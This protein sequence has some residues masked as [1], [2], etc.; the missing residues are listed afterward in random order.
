LLI[1]AFLYIFQA[2][3]TS[4]N[5]LVP[6]SPTEHV[7]YL[8]AMFFTPQD[9]AHSGSLSPRSVLGARHHRCLQPP[10]AHEEELTDE[11]DEAQDSPST[12][13]IPPSARNVSVCDSATR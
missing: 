5:M 8:T 2:P 10:P 4:R 6:V 7:F 11:H 13:S 3:T 12:D 9:G 1:S